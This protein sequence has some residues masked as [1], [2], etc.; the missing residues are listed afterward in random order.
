MKKLNPD[1]PK[2]Q[3]KQ[4][5]RLDFKVNLFSSLKRSI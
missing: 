4:T 5:Q 1:I 2:M 3:T